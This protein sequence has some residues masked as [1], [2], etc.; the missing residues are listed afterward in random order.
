MTVFA[1]HEVS[2]DLSAAYKFG[3]LRYINK[4]YI[5]GDQL[6]PVLRGTPTSVLYDP[7]ATPEIVDIKRDW[8]IPRGY[9]MNMDR[10]AAVFNPVTDYLLIAG[11]HLQ[12]LAMTAILSSWF[13]SFMVLRYDRKISD[14]IPV[15]LYSGLVP[16][17]PRVVRSTHIG[18][19]HY[20]QSRAEEARRLHRES[21]QILNSIGAP[22][23]TP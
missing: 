15:R 23:R 6:E 7:T 4:F 8:G 12:L 20:A 21:E 22:K 13:D 14:Y 17:S 9:R 10:T 1:V 18:E 16:G 2:D 19:T 11:D 5:H 3:G